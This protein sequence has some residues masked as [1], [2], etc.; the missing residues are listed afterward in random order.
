MAAVLVSVFATTGAAEASPPAYVEAAGSGGAICS[1]WLNTR[2]NSG[3]F[4][5]VQGQFHTTGDPCTLWLER[6]EI[7]MPVW[8]QLGTGVTTAFLNRDAYTSWFWDGTG[9]DS[10]VHVC[11]YRDAGTMDICG[12]GW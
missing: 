9:S 5:E 11:I 4:W 10:Q 3:G 1:G 12:D 7:G 8:T 2:W 6:W